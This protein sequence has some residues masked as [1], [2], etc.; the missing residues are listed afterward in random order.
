VP[1]FENKLKFEPEGASGYQ[2]SKTT[3]RSDFTVGFTSFRFE[4]TVSL[5]T[6]TAPGVS[7]LRSVFTVGF[8]SFQSDLRLGFTVGF[9]YR[10][11]GYRIY[12]PDLR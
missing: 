8:T 5:Y 10:I 2:T 4:F 1:K 3:L 7:D 6:K 12:V 11:Y 9:T